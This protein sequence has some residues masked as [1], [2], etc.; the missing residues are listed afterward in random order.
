M[1]L[2]TSRERV[3]IALNHEEADRVP[4]D[5]GGSRVTGISAVAYNNLLRQLGCKEDIHLYDIKQQLAAPSLE[6]IN[7]LGGDVIQLHR[8]GPTT[9]MPFLRLDRWKPGQ[10]TDGSPCLVPEECEEARP[11]GGMIELRHNSELFAR[12]AAE[13]FYFDVCHAPLASAQT[14][15]DIDAFEW[16]DPWSEREERYLKQRVQQLYHGTDKALFAGL[17]MLVCSFF[18][19]SLVLFGFENFMMK[20]IEDRDFIEYWLDAKLAHDFE[21][22]DKFL[23]VAGPCIEAIQMNDDF[24]AQDAL[25]IAPTIYREIFKPRQKKW[26]EFVK[27]RTRAKVFIHC[28]GAI[29]EILPDFIEIG[30]DILNPLQTSARG[31][32]PR[33]IKKKFGRNLSFWGGGVET[34][35]TL[36]FGSID[37]IKREVRERVK[38]LGQ[39]GGY[40]FATIH[41]I[42]PD[43]PPEKVLAIYETVAE[44][45]QYPL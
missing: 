10:L 14:P 44:C 45:G 7:R 2:L 21:I 12:R 19:I 38:L 36:P 31:M 13:S 16:P 27:A 42:Q 22:L 15:A 37:D 32:D 3:R 18:E 26:V 43:I 30:I 11:D 28:D 39:G 40:V 1:S 35:T 8:L 17:P 24:G 6:V 23:S 9:A 34:Q 33:P 4:V 29:N 5:F 41:N 25:Q 20:L